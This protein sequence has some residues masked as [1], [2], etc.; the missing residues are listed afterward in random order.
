MANIQGDFTMEQVYHQMGT[1]RQAIWKSKQAEEKKQELEQ[2]IVDLV[3]VW[4]QRHPKM[5]CR[6][7]F[8]SMRAADIVLGVGINKFEK[9]LKKYGLLVG[10]ARSKKP[11][12]SDGKG[13]GKYPNLASGMILTDINQLIVLDLTYIY[14]GNQ[15][16]YIFTIKDVYSQ[17]VWLVPSE[18]KESKFA[19]ECLWMFINHR[20]K[21][22][23]IGCVHHSDAGSEYG[24]VLYLTTLTD[25][26]FLISR[27]KSCKENGSAEQTHHVSKNMYIEAWGV[28][29]FAELQKA[30]SDFMYNNNYER[31]IKQ[32]GNMTPA[33]FEASLKHIPMGQRIK[34]VMHD[35]LNIE[36]RGG[37]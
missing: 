1:S 13:L 15:W 26:G 34:K 36:Q 14:V 30:C 12:G 8:H 7:L 24:S 19:L 23:I 16:C 29:T 17:W 2:S 37:I 4:R 35:F 10:K 32:L 20:G 18:T 3:I 6:P 31:A 27:S 22:A 33:Q 21:Q 11:Q 25:L 28:K 5:G 9:I